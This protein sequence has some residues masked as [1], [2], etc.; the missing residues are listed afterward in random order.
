MNITEQNYADYLFVLTPI[1]AAASFDRVRNEQGV[2]VQEMDYADYR[3]SISNQA[4][5]ESEYLV[6]SNLYDRINASVHPLYVDSFLAIGYDLDSSCKRK[7][8][9]PH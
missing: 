1:E 7:K 6:F 4:K 2:T 8:G 9:T 3:E 5:T